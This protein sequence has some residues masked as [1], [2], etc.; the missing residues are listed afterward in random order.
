MSKQIIRSLPELLEAGILTEETAE[1]IRG[2]YNN[3]NEQPQNHLFIVF[4]ILG[5]ILIGLGIILIIAQN[6]DQ[7]PKSIKT[8]FA[9]LPLIIGQLLGAYGLLKKQESITWRESTATFI[10]LMVGA[11][12]SLISQIY[13]IPGE[14]SSFILL[15]V[16]LGLPLV[17]LLKSSTAAFIYIIGISYYAGETGYWA[18]QSVES[19]LYWGLL[20][21]ILPHYYLLY[22]NNPESNF[23]TFLHWM[24]PLSVLITLGTLVKNVAELMFIAYFS[25]FGLYLLIGSTK[26]FEA[27]KSR[28]NGYRILGYLGTLSLLFAF[29]FKWLWE[30]LYKKDHSDTELISSPELIASV[31][32]TLAASILFLRIKENK[33]WQ[34]IHP[35]SLIFLLFIL[36]YI[37]GFFAPLISVILINL[38]VFSLGIFT[39]WRGA[40]INHLGILNLG[41]LIITILIICRFFDTNISFVLRGILFVG[42]GVGFFLANYW[43]LKKRNRSNNN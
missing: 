26:Y 21:L 14:L 35:V 34:D 15:W 23:L 1:K 41:L 8:T 29:S 13:N 12:I 25:L 36:S 16:L 11:S 5:A 19:Y 22:K 28:T 9:F 39:I 24:V 7:L 40:E 2:F 20:L 33:T 3:K 32:L 4:G 18:S 17:Y 30:E 38:T 10:F 31:L 37:I 43:M 42:V 6:W 27:Q